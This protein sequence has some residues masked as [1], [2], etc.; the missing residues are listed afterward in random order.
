[1]ITKA[2][3]KK[4]KRTRKSLEAAKRWVPTMNGKEIVGWRIVT[5]F[6]AIK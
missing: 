5:D 6:R 3:R 4:Q 2:M 1:M